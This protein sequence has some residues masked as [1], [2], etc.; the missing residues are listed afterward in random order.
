MHNSS[1]DCRLSHDTSN[2]NTDTKALK[3]THDV[4]LTQFSLVQRQNVHSKL[5]EVLTKINSI[6]RFLDL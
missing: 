5:S 4:I 1:S 2:T 6:L 3:T